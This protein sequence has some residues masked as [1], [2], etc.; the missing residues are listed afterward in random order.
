MSDKSTAKDLFIK[1]DILDSIN[2]K[3]I[4]REPSVLILVDENKNITLKERR[5]NEER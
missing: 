1:W 4:K 5:P 2:E 3:A